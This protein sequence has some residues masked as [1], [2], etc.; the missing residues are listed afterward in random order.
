LPA[1]QRQ[2][3]LLAHADVIITPASTVTLE[4]AIFDTPTLVLAYNDSD[5]DTIRDVLEKLTFVRHFK[6]IVARKLVPVAH[7]AEETVCWI[8]RLL[9]DPGAFQAERKEIVRDW[10]GFTDGKSASRSA[11]AIANLADGSAPADSQR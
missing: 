1:L 10:V 9:S 6:A 5:P 11:R 4:G 7:S 3:N 2:A 8:N